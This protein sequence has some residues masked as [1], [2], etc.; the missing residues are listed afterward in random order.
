MND[1]IL[2]YIENDTIIHRLSGTTKL[3]CFLM[4][5]I[6]VMTSYDTRFLFFVTLLSLILFKIAEIPWQAVSYVVKFVLVFAI[7]NLLAIY[8]FEPEYGVNLYNSRSLI[9][10]GLGRYSLTKEQLFYE[11]NVAIKYFSTIPLALIFIFTTSPSEF[12]SSLNKIGISY[13]V[14]YSVSLALRYIP[15]IQ[16]SYN[17]IK[18]ASQARGIEMS[19]KASLGQRMKASSNIIWPLIFDSLNRIETISQAMELRRFGK[20]STRTWISYRPFKKIDIVAIVISA[21][22]TVLGIYLFSVNGG[23]FYNPF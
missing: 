8:I 13:K 16:N 14:S 7:L 11:L 19:K 23:R 15:D 10:E 21:I 6:I 22:I 3:I 12:A 1:K 4:L 5:S 20:E 9:K 17:D 2:G 18:L